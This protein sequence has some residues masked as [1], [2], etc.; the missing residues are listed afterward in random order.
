M[1][2]KLAALKREAIIRRLEA[3]ALAAAFSLEKPN[4]IPPS[5]T[6][7]K[8]REILKIAGEYY[9]GERVPTPQVRAIANA[10]LANVRRINN[11]F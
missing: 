3:D 5:V 1:T 9:R 4:S 7:P 10:I 8:V 6:D 2:D 11:R